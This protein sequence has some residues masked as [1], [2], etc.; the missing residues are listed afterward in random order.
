MFLNINFNLSEIFMKDFKSKIHK[1]G[2]LFKK[3]F[4]FWN[5]EP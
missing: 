3:R 4:I 1:N 5:I 2:K